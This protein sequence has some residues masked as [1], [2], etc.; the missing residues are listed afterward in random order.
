MTHATFAWCGAR[1]RGPPRWLE[2]QKSQSFTLG[3]HI[4]AALRAITIASSTDS[5][6]KG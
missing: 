5:E 2:R 3:H 4:T 6:L 1:A